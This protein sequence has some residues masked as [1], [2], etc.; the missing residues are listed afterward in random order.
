[1]KKTA[2]YLLFFIL[3]LGCN[4]QEKEKQ[5]TQTEKKEKAIIKPQEKWDVKKEYDEFG[6]LI[7]YDS[8]YS[9]SYSNIEG[10]TIQVNLDSIMNSF[11]GYF[12]ENTPF[13]WDERF[14]YFP[15]NDSLF[16]NDFFQDDFFFKQ[17]NRHPLDISKM[18]RRMDS[19]R[20]DFMKKFYPGLM[21]SRKTPKD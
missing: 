12:E 7:K 2:I 18:M 5:E 15:Q 3:F 4:S 14:S 17:W 21:Q 20:N 19:T 16:M 10:D 11:R 13:K 6:N 8:I 1:M 9:Y